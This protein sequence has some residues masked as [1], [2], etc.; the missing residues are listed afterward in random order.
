MSAAIQYSGFYI[1]GYYLN[2]HPLDKKF[3][4]PV[5]ILGFLSIAFT[6]LATV[7]FSFKLLSEQTVY[8][9]YLL[10][11]T[12]FSSC[13]IF[14]FVQNACKNRSF[15][16]KKNRIIAALSKYSF[17]VY[18]CHLIV[19]KTFKRLDIIKLDL[20]YLVIFLIVL[21]STAIIS[22]IASAIL[23]HIP[24]LKKYIV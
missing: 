19:I 11:T 7:Y 1:L 4:I 24:V 15:S 12:L 23:N 20:P 10:P 18:L 13:S 9:D 14:I 3:R 16:E 5:Y 8:F 17:G 2:K 6:A 21:I 22:T